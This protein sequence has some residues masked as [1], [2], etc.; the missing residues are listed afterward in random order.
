MHCHLETCD[1]V[2][3]DHD[4]LDSPRSTMSQL[5]DIVGVPLSR[6]YGYLCPRPGFKLTGIRRFHRN[7]LA[8]VH[9]LADEEL[10]DIIRF[11]FRVLITRPPAE[12]DTGVQASLAQI[13]LVLFTTLLFVNRRQLT[14]VDAEYYTLILWFA[15][16]H[17]TL[18]FRLCMQFSVLAAVPARVSTVRLVRSRCLDFLHF[19]Q[20]FHPRLFLAEMPHLMAGLNLILPS[21]TMAVNLLNQ[22]HNTTQMEGRRVGR[23]LALVAGVAESDRHK[24]SPGL[25]PPTS[26]L[27]EPLPVASQRLQDTTPGPSGPRT[28]LEPLVAERAIRAARE[29]PSPGCEQQRLFVS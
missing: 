19:L 4:E 14:T 7:L 5:C 16:T 17:G 24:L 28:P 29:V 10:L 9:L 1:G 8:W 18:G 2:R 26:D 12:I 22:L 15:P 6:H 13:H 20:R 23:Y 27:C 3:L 21:R 25:E 11:A